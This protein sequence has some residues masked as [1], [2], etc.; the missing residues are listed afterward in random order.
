[1]AVRK[2][3]T[4]SVRAAGGAKSPLRHLRR[5]VAAP[6]GGAQQSPLSPAPEHPASRGSTPR[7]TRAEALEIIFASAVRDGEGFRHGALGAPRFGKTFHVRDV[8]DEA[9]ERGIVDVAFVHDV[10]KRE[11]QYEGIVRADPADLRARPPADDDPPVVV[12]HPRPGDVAIVS[13]EDV[14]ALGWQTARAGTRTVVV[15]DE[16]YAGL[17]SRQT[18]DGATTGKVFREG[19]SQGLS[20]C[21]TTQIPQSLPTE[22]CDL[23]ETVALFHLE[24][25]SASYATDIFRLPAEAE[26]LLSQL[27]RGE[28]LLFSS[29]QRW[30]GKIYGPT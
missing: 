14:A 10:K 25:R 22:T 27:G 4:T 29:Y 30:D 11:V 5:A 15:P 13:L 21:W 19:S 17:K 3:P 6:A 1:M 28:F 9:L 18:W 8:V 16:L 7:G 20:I 12:F 24:G 26:A 23:S 2:V